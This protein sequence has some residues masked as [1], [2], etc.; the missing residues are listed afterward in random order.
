V[1]GGGLFHVMLDANI[2]APQVACADYN[3]TRTVRKERGA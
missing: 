1:I 2:A 3:G